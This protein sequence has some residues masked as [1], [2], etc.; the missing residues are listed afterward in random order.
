MSI[1]NLVLNILLYLWMITRVTWAICNEK[2]FKIAFY[3][4]KFSRRD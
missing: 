2:S 3:F 4:S 1:Q